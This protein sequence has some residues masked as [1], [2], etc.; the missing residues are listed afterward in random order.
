MPDEPAG[1]SDPTPSVARITVALPQDRD[2]TVITITVDDVVLG[3]P[4]E[5]STAQGTVELQVQGSGTQL[6]TIY[7]DGVK[8]W[9]NS[10][11]FPSGSGTAD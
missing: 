3:E 11:T 9:S 2:S 1:P 6:V 8:G 4:F 10:V 5:V 7:F